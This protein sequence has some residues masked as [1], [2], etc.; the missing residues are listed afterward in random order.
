[1][2]KLR[3]RRVKLKPSSGFKIGYFDGRTEVEAFIKRFHM[4]AKNNGWD[5]EEKLCHLTCALKSPADQLL[6]EAGADDIT[7]WSD[8]V[9]RLRDRHFILFYSHIYIRR[10]SQ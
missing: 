8:L 3:R 9:R 10:H 7:V 5:D 6:W 1:M 2:R 4:C